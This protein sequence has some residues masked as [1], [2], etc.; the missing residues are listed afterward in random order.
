IR[1]MRWSKITLR[2]S[3]WTSSY[4][5][6][7]L[8]MSKLRAST[9]CCAF[10]SALLIQGWMMASP[11][12]RPSRVSMLSRRSEPKMRIRS[13]SSDRKNFERPGSP[14][15]PAGRFFVAAGLVPSR[16]DDVEAAGLDFGPGR[17]RTLG[18][19]DL[20]GLLR[21]QHDGAEAL[22]VG[23]DL[24]DLCRLLRLVGDISGLLLETHLKRAAELDVGTA[25]GHVGRDRD[26]AGNAGFS[27]D[28]G[29]LLL[30]AGVQPR[31][32]LGLL[33]GAGRGVELVQRAFLAE[34]DLLVAVLPQVL[35]E[36]L[37]LL[38]RGG[39]AQPRLRAQTGALDLGQD[40]GVFLVL[41][42]IDLVVLVE[43][44][45]RQIGRDLQHFELVDV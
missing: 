33:A 38:D 7:F 6:R 10:S 14:L 18:R 41:G 36:H 20:D 23:L 17:F 22:D 44:R 39:A 15:G 13:S 43:A 32:Q 1:S 28:I 29:F 12:F 31:E 21:L 26:G 8:R 45:D 35:G 25:A 40:R 27:D 24:L 9:F 5:S 3:F 11:S 30:E 4:L 16:A 19:L 34:V 37:G 2:W 42:A